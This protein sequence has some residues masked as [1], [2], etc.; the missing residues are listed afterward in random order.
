MALLLQMAQ[1]AWLALLPVAD[2]GAEV[3]RLKVGTEVV[4][5]VV[6]FDEAKGIRARRVD[7]GALLDLA[8]E[9]MAEEDAQRIRAARGYLSDEPEPIMVDA[10]KL[11][12]MNGSEVTGIIVEQGTQ[13]IRLRRGLQTWDYNRQGVRA[14]TPVQ[15]DAL[16]VYDGEELYGQELA[17]RSPQTALE[18]YNLAIWCE[19]L[20][21]WPRVQENLA[22]VTELDPTFKSVIVEGK[23]KRAAMRIEF[24]ED[25][26]Q[27][28][29]LQRLAQR[30]QYDAALAGIEEFLTKK[31]S[32]AMRGEF[33]KQRQAISVAREK[34]VRQQVV[35]HFFSYAERVARQVATEK[36]I[37][38]KQAR[39]RVEREG[40]QLIAEATAKQLRIDAAEVLK[41]W[42]DPKRAT[43]SPHYANYGA[44]TFTLGSI[45]KVQK[46]FENVVQES[47]PKDPNAGNDGAD[48]GDYLERLK[49]ILEQKQKEAE[50]AAKNKGR[51][52]E[53]KRGPEIADVPPTADEWWAAAGSDERTQYLLACWADSD[54]NV[55]ILKAEARQCMQCAGA[56]V[57]RYFD[58]NA[59]FKF[60][61]CS[62]CKSLGIDRILRFH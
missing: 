7:D 50:E 28:G 62:R 19:S 16:E 57:I 37:S 48:P 8:F 61:P 44:G 46:N 11:L 26:A 38:L 51:K 31:P 59:D 6:E 3:V 24:G 52:K 55:Q 32:S 14:V 20:Q 12:L 21:L 18:F 60:V 15:V 13:T 9:Q 47:A 42:Q 29:K 40:T 4:V 49:K 35:I 22:H 23:V 53:T 56:G 5:E 10:M 36:E 45:E 27:L 2:G 1:M 39:Q 17:R 33:E 25:S 43:A 54:P 41:Q 34:W 58:H 30:N